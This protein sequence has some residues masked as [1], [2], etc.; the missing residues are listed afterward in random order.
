MLYEGVSPE[1][2]GHWTEFTTD[3]HLSE[4]VRIAQRAPIASQ[5]SAP[6]GIPGTP[7]KR[8]R[9]PTFLLYRKKQ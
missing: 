5:D 7:F 3:S 2:D 8:L 1:C 6:M 9:N 4:A